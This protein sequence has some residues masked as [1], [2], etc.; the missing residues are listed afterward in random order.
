ML[1]E[2]AFRIIAYSLAAAGLSFLAADDWG[3]KE[4]GSAIAFCAFVLW[5]EIEILEYLR[6]RGPLRVI[7]RSRAGRAIVLLVRDAALVAA[8]VFFACPAERVTK[9]EATN[10]AAFAA[11]VEE[12]RWPAR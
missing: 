2:S 1:T 5:S 11:A 7:R 4:A 12:A 6:A 10:W 9:V 3:P 8:V